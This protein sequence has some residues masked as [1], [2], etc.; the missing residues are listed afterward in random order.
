MEI[1]NSVV[2]FWF[3]KV[4]NP[5]LFSDI[6]ND[7]LKEYFF[8]F[9]TIGVPANIDP[10][11]A[12]LNAVSSSS[13]SNL[14]ISLINARL[15]TNFDD[16]YNKDFNKCLNYLKERVLKIFETL[17][18]C[19]IEVCYSAIFV[20][21][22]EKNDNPTKRIKEKFLQDNNLD[23]ITEIGI[24]LSKEQYNKY[25]INTSINN[26]REITITKKIENNGQNGNEIFL[27]LISLAGSE[28]TEYLVNSIEVNDKLSYNNDEKYR[29]AIENL[30][31]MFII[32][33]DT[34]KDIIK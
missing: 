2:T 19:E 24:R 9:N 32:I 17:K 16:N 13:H 23:N 25:Y 30:E 8:D 3:K 7:N 33:D 29:T 31:E 6:L 27:P 21:M 5:K 12:R 1:K 34:I 28:Q 10:L 4:D 22:E 26:A 14:E 20:N 11:I 15:N 18:K